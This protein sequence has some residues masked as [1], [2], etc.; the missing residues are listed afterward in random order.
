M[1]EKAPDLT[2]YGTPGGTTR[3]DLEDWAARQQ[4]GQEDDTPAPQPP[5]PAAEEGETR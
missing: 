3:K 2:S 1:D 5:T 4:H